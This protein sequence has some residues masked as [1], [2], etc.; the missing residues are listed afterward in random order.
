MSWLVGLQAKAAA[1]GAAVLVVLGFLLR[2][3]MVTHQRDKAKV[4]AETLKARHHVA[5]VQKKI[6]REE[7]KKLLKELSSIEKEIE[8]DDDEFQGVDNLTNS[9]DF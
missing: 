8:K 2:L 7:E 3:K 1:I 9:N 4:V 6:K 5:V